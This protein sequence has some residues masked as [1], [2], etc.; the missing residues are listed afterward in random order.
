ME[1]Q[2]RI[3]LN[4][5]AEFCHHLA[6]V[7]ASKAGCGGHGPCCEQCNFLDSALAELQT[8]LL[9]ACASPLNISEA[10]GALRQGVSCKSSE[11]PRRRFK[12]IWFF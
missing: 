5:G 3:K 6:E 1:L 4:I 11:D 9:K 8:L 12:Y 10:M 7:T 2:V